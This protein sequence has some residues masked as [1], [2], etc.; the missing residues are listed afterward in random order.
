MT[1]GM[2]TLAE[3]SAYNTFDPNASYGAGVTQIDFEF[4]NL[5]NWDVIYRGGLSKDYGYSEYFSTGVSSNITGLFRYQNSNGDNLFIYSQG[6]NVY[7]LVAGVATSIHSTLSS[8]AFTDFETAGDNLIICDGVASPYKWSGTGATAVIGGSP[9][10]GVRQTLY[11]QNRLWMFSLT[12]DNSLVYYSDVE[13]ID[14]GYATQF[15]PCNKNDGQKITGISRLFIPGSLEP[16]IFVSKERSCGII[17]GTG[18]TDNPYTYKEIKSDLG[19][20]GWR[21]IVSYQQDIAFLTNAGVSTYRTALQNTNLQENFISKNIRD[22]FTS[23]NQSTLPNA[24]SLYD[25]KQDRIYFAVATSSNTYPDT[26]YSY[27]LKTNSWRKKTGFTS[28]CAFIDTDGTVYHGDAAG[29]INKWDPLVNNYNGSAINATLQTPFIDFYD[30]DSFK[31]IVHS[32]MT[33]RGKGNYNLSI[34]CSLDYGKR[35]GSTH[36]LNLTAGSYVWGGGVWTNNPSTYQWGASPLL[37]KTFFPRDI[38]Q[39][40]S[41]T[42][43]QTGANQPVDIID[44]VIEV[45]YLNKY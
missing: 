44:W 45:E 6:T 1:G 43:N 7:K 32:K 3:D 22:Q 11:T 2:N 25:W 20:F 31:R 36:A 40:I 38:F 24:W 13:N 19:V 14:A 15:V 23:L 34:G 16:L 37:K 4:K 9:P 27:N 39:N 18:A 28:T 30:A 10:I 26:I 17:S 8:G 33:V 12:N 29:K 42:I 41:F 35:T 21:H 5:E